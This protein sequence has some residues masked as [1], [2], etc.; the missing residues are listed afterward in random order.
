MAFEAFENHWVTLDM[1][2]LTGYNVTTLLFM[3]FKV[4]GTSYNFIKK[5]LKIKIKTIFILVSS[6]S[7]LCVRTESFAESQGAVDFKLKKH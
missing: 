5:N 7:T 1:D 2:T 3:A 4:C 6:V